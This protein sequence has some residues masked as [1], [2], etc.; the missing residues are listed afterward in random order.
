VLSE[1]LSITRIDDLLSQ[2]RFHEAPKRSLFSFPLK[3]AE[4]F[5]IGV[6]GYVIWIFKWKE[7]TRLT[8]INIGMVS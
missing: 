7:V 4:G 1:R 6:K 8:V 2:M 5:A 3:L